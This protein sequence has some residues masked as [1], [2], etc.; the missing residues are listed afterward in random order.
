M[1][2]IKLLLILLL[3]IPNSVTAQS[4]ITVRNDEHKI[5]LSSRIEYLLDQEGN[6][7]FEDVKSGKAGKFF[8]N[9]MKVFSRGYTK[10][11]YW[12]R[13]ILQSPSESTNF[14]EWI[15]EIGYP[16][17][18]YITVFVEEKEGEFKVIDGGDRY[19][20]NKRE[21]LYNKFGFPFTLEGGTAKRIFIRVQTEGSFQFPITLLDKKSL[22]E[23]INIEKIIFGIIFGIL[24][25]M[26]CYNSFLFL[27]THILDYLFYVFYIFWILMF[28]LSLQG[29]TFE[30]IF[31]N[32]PIIA[33]KFLGLS[34]I[35]IRLSSIIFI[36]LFLNLKKY[37][38]ILHKGFIL[39]FFVDVLINLPLTIFG[40]YGT[41]IE[42]NTVFII[43]GAIYA[44]I[45]G[46]EQLLKGSLSARFFLTA[47]SILLI[48]ML[49]LAFSKF[50]ILPSNFFTEH[51][52]HFG[53]VFESIVLA[54]GLGDRINRERSEKLVAIS[55]NNQLKE[56]SLRDPLTNLY[57][58]RFIDQV[59]AD[60]IL[61]GLKSVRMN[62][63]R[64][65]QNQH[66]AVFLLD[67]DHF[68]EVND[69]YGHDS[70][71]LVLQ[72]FSKVLQ[73]LIRKN[74]T[75]VRWG[76]EEFLILLR[77]IESQFIMGMAEKFLK[78]I[79][80][81]DFTILDGSKIHKTISIGYT[82]LPFYKEKPDLVFLEDAITLI[83]Y[84]LYRAKHSG[85]DKAIRVVSKNCP[86]DNQKFYDYCRNVEEKEENEYF[87]FIDD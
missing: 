71:D 83:D 30:W 86:G 10:D 85:R 27:T 76:G 23:S 44:F 70:G 41:A 5:N 22:A 13:I 1:R 62:D 50:G 43:V 3:I 80:Q 59:V 66:Y 8:P 69:K 61:N 39:L 42:I 56:L 68:K 82:S 38:N 58:R 45:I 47:W 31:P 51:G 2:K 74:D 84:A 46:I 54:L 18:D 17:L 40:S 52:M 48:G 4:I 64:K 33:G 7:S 60:E 11:T 32:S 78:E 53:A 15:L 34:I 6:F 19:P 73:S 28:F 9:D 87:Q 21:I 37:N 72:K 67:I 14:K 16:M 24:I 75:V 65:D 55:R 57:N 36:Y 49:G 77:G 63:L 81:E 25:G 79:R 20:F 29:F 26:I 35:G 12:F